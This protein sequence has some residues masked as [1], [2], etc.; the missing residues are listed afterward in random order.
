MSQETSIPFPKL[1]SIKIL[2]FVPQKDYNTTNHRQYKN[3]TKEI[4]KALKQHF[5][6]EVVNK[7]CN[8]NGN[9]SVSK[10]AGLFSEAS[11]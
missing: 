9:F 8:L 11:F 4:I 7:Q 5:G 10:T 3:K 6:T 2:K 1:S